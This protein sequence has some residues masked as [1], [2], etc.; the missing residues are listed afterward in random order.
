MVHQLSMTCIIDDLEVSWVTVIQELKYFRLKFVV[1][2]IRWNKPFFHIVVVHIGQYVCQLLD[3]DRYR[4]AECPISQSVSD[5][6][7]ALP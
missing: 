4:E 5:Q 6:L 7:R 2:V 1:R 3:L